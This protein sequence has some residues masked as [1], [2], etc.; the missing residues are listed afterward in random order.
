MTKLVQNSFRFIGL[1]ALILLVFTAKTSK[2][3]HIVG[4]DLTYQCVSSTPG[5]YYVEYKWYRDCVGIP[6]CGCGAT[7]PLDPAC[8]IDINII[9]ANGNCAGQTFPNQKLT[10]VPNTSAYDVIQL[11]AMSTTVCSNCGTRTPGS[12]T[13]G[14]EIFTFRGTINLASLTSDPTCCLFNIGFGECCRNAAI[15]TF[16]NPSGLSF[17]SGGTLNKCMAPC[18]SAPAF[19]NDPVAI[20]CAGQEFTYNLGAIDPDGD[21]LSY[22]FG[23]SLTGAGVSVP[24]APPFTA[25]I[26]FPVRG[27]NTPPNPTVNVCDPLLPV[28]GFCIDPITGDI[29]FYPNGAFVANLVIEVKQ[30]KYIN[31]V[32]TLAGIT[33]RDIQFYSITC[34]ANNPPVIKTYDPNTGLPITGNKFYT[35]ANK[36]LCLIIAAADDTKAWD[37][38]DLKWN[39]PVTMTSTGATFKPLYNVAQRSVQ[40]PKRDSFLFCWT[41]PADKATSLPH[42]FIVTAKDRMCPVPARSSK[43][44]GI[45]VGKIPQAVIN[46]VDKR[47]GN[48]EFSFAITNNMTVNNAYTQIRIETAPGSDNYT[49]YSGTLPT[50]S[51]PPVIPVAGKF[52]KHSFTKSG[53]HKVRLRL[54]NVAPIGQDCPNDRIVDSVFIPELIKTSIRDTFNCFGVPVKVT[55]STKGGTPLGGAPGFYNYKYY[56]G[57]MTSQNL[58]VK[59]V[60]SPGGSS[61]DSSAF[62]NPTNAGNTTAYKLLVTD[63]YG[64][65]DSVPLSILTRNLPKRE[66]PTSI[67]ICSGASDTLNAGTSNE[68]VGNWTWR[69][70]P[71]YPVLKDSLS[72]F[73][74]PSDSGRYYVTKIDTWGC[75]RLDSSDVFVNRAV[76]VFAGKNDTICFKDPPLVLKAIGTTAAIDSFQWCKMPITTDS[77]II[78]RAD[79]L[80][81][82]P[83]KTSSYRVKGYITYK[84]VTCSNVDTI[85]VAVNPLPVIEPVT[86]IILCKSSFSSIS[87]PRI[88]A[89]NAPEVQ[90]I[91]SYPMNPSA[92]TGGDQL[93]TNKLLNLPSETD[94][95]PYGN[96]I[97][98][99]IKDKNKCSIQDSLLVAIYPV[100]RADAGVSKIICDNQ[101]TKVINLPVKIATSSAETW[102]G[103]GVVKTSTL[104]TYGFDINAKDIKFAPDTN[105]LTYTSK[106]QFFPTMEV[107]LNPDVK[108]VFVNSPPNGCPAMDTA[109]YVVI[110]TPLLDPGVEPFIC[111]S[112]GVFDLQKEIKQRDT[113][114]NSYWEFAP[115]DIAY[116]PAL[117]QKRYFDPGS[118]VISSPANPLTIPRQFNLLYK[119]DATGCLVEKPINVT[120]TPNP[121]VK[122]IVSDSA[123]CINDATANFTIYSSISNAEPADVSGTKLTTSPANIMPALNTST[124]KATLDLSK[125]VITPG[126]YKM[127]FNYVD[128][129]TGCINADTNQFRIQAPPEVQ[130]PT[131]KTL[132]EYEADKFTV[133]P[134]K[135]PTNPPYGIAWTTPDGTQGNIV[136]DA[137]GMTYTASNQDKLNKKVTFRAGSQF[138]NFNLPVGTYTFEDACALY[139]AF[140]EMVFNIKPKPFADFTVPA[141]V[142]VDPGQL[143]ATFTAFPTNVSAPNYYWFENNVSG[144]ALNSNPAADN[145]F[146]KIYTKAGKTNVFLMVE[147]DACYDTATHV[148]EA[149]PTPVAEFSHLPYTTTI[150]NPYYSFNN[151]SDPKSGIYT[152]LLYTWNFGKGKPASASDY[153]SVNPQNVQ[154]PPDTSNHYVTLIARN[155][156]GCADTV[157]HTVKVE[158]DITVFIPS[159][160]YPNSMVDC[161]P[162]SFQDDCN[163]TFKIVADGIESIDIMVF[164]RWGQMVFRTNDVKIGWNGTDMKTNQD[165]QQDAY[166]YQVNAVSSGGKKYSYSG[167]VILFR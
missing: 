66:L 121:D 81:V 97:Y 55:G 135:S 61:A 71:A 155:E 25:N 127:Y 88:D 96:Y 56:L 95:Y 105:I 37:T 80:A 54:T 1:V 134:V 112:N 17:Y 110:K 133:Q 167:S 148:V 165:C 128:P 161:K 14:I 159:A 51:P 138:N 164:D 91:W 23:Q 126:V 52:I 158:P 137:N 119:N 156:W 163:K 78:S 160:F 28:M 47:C 4:G 74:F 108:G 53:W 75:I 130:L 22:A 36:E 46:K 82:T 41:P 90:N 73:V 18:N 102:Y 42:Y 166:I 114:T 13:P 11:C 129:T 7:G 58:L 98:L 19:T 83:E 157:T 85:I 45:T 150:A 141:G 8:S 100:P 93:N 104:N 92:I 29:R 106:V 21:S 123:V 79:T 50:T 84:G 38:T 32:P 132:C 122:L 139:P 35:C 111:L 33:R 107:V 109:V 63:I 26:P 57:D 162:V 62:L 10:V 72:Q 146:S 43:S 149:Y 115:S 2:A 68:T 125:N 145:T 64:C 87:L 20:T 69:K 12:F 15:T 30:W 40:G 65:K 16:L 27:V 124:G 94:L 151:E 5:I 103:R 86:P 131:D 6:M 24:Y 44:F 116:N 140:D 9:A 101:A 120:V 34:A 39:N 136:S 70:S 142:C 3:S 154:F 89:T 147:Q 152:N 31:G 143:D 144:A 49:T 117:T 99:E 48:Y 77:T 67:R 118:P 113:T 153:T 60:P 76:P 59:N